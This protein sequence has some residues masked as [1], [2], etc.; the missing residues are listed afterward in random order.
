MERIFLK[1]ILKEKA[2]VVLQIFITAAASMDD[3]LAAVDCVTA[4]DCFRK[5]SSKRGVWC[6]A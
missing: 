1:E 2:L 4:W 6:K 5:K 3:I